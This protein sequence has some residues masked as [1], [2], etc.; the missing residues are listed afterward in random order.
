MLSGFCPALFEVLLCS[1][2]LATDTHLKLLDRVV[3]GDSFLTWG[4]F[5]CN[6]AHRRLWQYYVCCTR[7]DATQCTLILWCPTMQCRTCQ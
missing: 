6:I 5:E 2:V 7:L 1:A 4:V 3:S